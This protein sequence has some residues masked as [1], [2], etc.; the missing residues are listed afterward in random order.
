MSSVLI[1]QKKSL[2]NLYMSLKLNLLQYLHGDRKWAFWNIP[3]L[4]CLTENQKDIYIY[5]HTYLWLQY[6]THLQQVRGACQSMAT[7]PLFNP[8]GKKLTAVTVSFF[9]F[10]SSWKGGRQREPAHG[11]NSMLKG[12]KRKW[13]ETKQRVCCERA[14]QAHEWKCRTN[15]EWGLGPNKYVEMKVCGSSSPCW[16]L[17]QRFPNWCVLTH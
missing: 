8:T 17:N 16:G 15:E 14:G 9:L 4:W 11:L 1:S 3:L 2:H 7:V 10:P 5:T 13:G 6:R 12:R